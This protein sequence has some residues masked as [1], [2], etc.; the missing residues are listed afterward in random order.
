MSD[1]LDPRLLEVFETFDAFC[2][3][4]S[5]R[6]RV[7]G[8]EYYQQGYSIRLGDPALVEGHMRESINDKWIAMEIEERDEGV[9]FTFEVKHLSEDQYKS[10]TRKM[11]RKQSAFR[12]S[13]GPSKSFGGIRGYNLH[14]KLAEALKL[15]DDLIAHDNVTK[16]PAGTEVNV[17]DPDPGLPDVDWDGTTSNVDRDKL[18]KAV[19]D[20]KEFDKIFKE[21]VLLEQSSSVGAFLTSK[22]HEG[23]TVAADRAFAAGYLT[24]EE[25]IAMSDAITDALK[26]FT[27]VMKKKFPKIYRREMDGAEAISMS[28]GSLGERIERRISEL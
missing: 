10:P 13:F 21:S 27:A 4:N 24:Q 16:I 1:S 3:K 22:I 5:I 6:Y 15:K 23:F 18:E 12:S 25:R 11:I 8:N 26:T 20:K 28:R 9:L 7:E 2:R 17:H 14:K 19:A